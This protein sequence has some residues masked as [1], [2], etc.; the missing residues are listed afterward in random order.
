MVTNSKSLGSLGSLGCLG[1]LGSLGNF[2]SFKKFERLGSRR[3]PKN[4][5]RLGIPVALLR[6][7]GCLLG[8]TCITYTCCCRVIQ[9]LNTQA[10]IFL[11]S[12]KVTPRTFSAIKIPIQ[13]EHSLFSIQWLCVQI[14]QRYFRISNL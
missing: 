12:S 11:K 4:P 8:I 13:G 10:S 3:G 5:G 6:I 14:I 7:L 2:G 9:I 1:S